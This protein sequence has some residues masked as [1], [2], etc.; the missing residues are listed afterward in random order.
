MPRLLA[1]DLSTNVGF[2]LLERGNRPAFGTL[3]LPPGSPGARFRRLREWLSEMLS[4]HEFDGLA[5][6]EPI[7]PRHSGDLATTMETLTL[8][9]GLTAVVQL[10]ASERGLPVRGVPV[11]T[12]KK[13]LT[14]SANA[15][16]DEMVV[17]AMKRMNWPV[18]NDHEADAGAVGVSA[19]HLIWPNAG[20][21]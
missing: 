5:F 12:A 17:A 13:T 20:A 8:L 4:V 2:A 14:G 9:W 19:Y 11:K 16:K 10:F 1:L 6:E 18:A 3:V 21:A 15:S 7:L